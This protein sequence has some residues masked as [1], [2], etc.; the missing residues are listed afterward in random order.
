MKLFVIIFK[1]LLMDS[2]KDIIWSFKLKFSTKS[3]CACDSKYLALF[4]KDLILFSRYRFSYWKTT[5][6]KARIYFYFPKCLILLTDVVSVTVS[7]LIRVLLYFLLL[8]SGL[9]DIFLLLG[10]SIILLPSKVPIKV[11][12]FRNP[13]EGDRST[14]I[15]LLLII[16]SCIFYLLA[17]LSVLF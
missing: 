5:K 10:Y 12:Y 14:R 4:S 6:R 7:L 2:V 17:L 8:S 13:E 16:C 9:F 15:L 11:S 1:I 3:G